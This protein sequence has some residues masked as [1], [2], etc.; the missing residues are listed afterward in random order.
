ML[1]VLLLSFW[2]SWNNANKG[3][4]CF[5][6]SHVFVQTRSCLLARNFINQLLTP[7]KSV[8]THSFQCGLASSR[9]EEIQA[10][11]SDGYTY[12]LKINQMAQCLMWVPQRQ[13]HIHTDSSNVLKNADL[14]IIHLNGNTVLTQ[15]GSW[16]RDSGVLMQCSP[17]RCFIDQLHMYEL[18]N[19]LMKPALL[20]SI[21]LSHQWLKQPRPFYFY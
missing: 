3:S 6:I 15:P 9:P 12:K 13:P 19:V 14:F 16:L 21:L 5:A 20:K 4:V 18:M 10:Q 7:A 1:H 17:T 11:K 2:L 8:W